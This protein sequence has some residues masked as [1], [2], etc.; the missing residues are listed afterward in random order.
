MR[1]L[2]HILKNS[3]FILRWFIVILASKL[4]QVRQYVQLGLYGT[5]S[6]LVLLC[7]GLMGYEILG[8][9]KPP[10]ICSRVFEILRVREDILAVTGI[11]SFLDTVFQRGVNR[12]CSSLF[13]SVFSIVDKS[14]YP[15]CWIRPRYYLHDILSYCLAANFVGDVLTILFV[16]TDRERTITARWK[17]LSICQ[18]HLIYRYS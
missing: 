10:N 7:V 6:M 11:I 12:S 9:Q 3:F 1:A 13:C 5:F 14:P 4:H 18:S 15:L 8:S 16:N 2:W 17:K